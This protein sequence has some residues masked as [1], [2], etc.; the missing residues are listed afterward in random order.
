METERGDPKKAIAAVRRIPR[1]VHMVVVA[2]AQ[3]EYISAIAIAA[4]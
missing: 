1:Q 4:A 3:A 2:A